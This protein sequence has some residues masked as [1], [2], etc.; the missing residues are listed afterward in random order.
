MSKALVAPGTPLDALDPRQRLAVEL[1]TNPLLGR[2][3]GNKAASCRAAGYEGKNAAVALTTPEARAAVAWLMDMKTA[4]SENVKAY[5][6]GFSMDAARK[7]VKMLGADDGV[8]VIPLPEDALRPPEK[9]M[10]VDK[11][12]KEYLIGWDDGHLK[13]A[14]RITAANRAAAG[15]IKESREALKIL[16]AYHIGTPE[17][18]N[19]NAAR[20]KEGDPLDLGALTDEELKELARH[21]QEVRDMKQGIPDV[22]V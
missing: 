4:E 3:F 8:A 14:D 19:K 22:D 13:V 9:I 7:L 20:A 17:Q 6:T 10:G 18:A 12:G 11:N 2:T 1:Y 5:L 15:L 16:L 21:V